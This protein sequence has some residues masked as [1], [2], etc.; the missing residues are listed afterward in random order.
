MQV[1]NILT[2]A[3][4]RKIKMQDTGH[5]ADHAAA[6]S[7]LSAPLMTILSASSGSGPPPLCRYGKKPETGHR[8]LV[9]SY[10]NRLV[11]RL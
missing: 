11:S 1:S 3:S 6:R 8:E 9:G 5:V 7:S 2:L 4:F 10:P